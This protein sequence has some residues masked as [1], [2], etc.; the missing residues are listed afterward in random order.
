MRGAR[1]YAYARVGPRSVDKRI[2]YAYSSVPEGWLWPVTSP[3][4]P[5]QRDDRPVKCPERWEL[6]PAPLSWP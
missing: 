6:N 1:L 5:Q 4:P 2:W 3:G